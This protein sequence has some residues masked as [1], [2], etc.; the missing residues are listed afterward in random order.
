MKCF[1]A[2]VP[3]VAV[4]LCALA[5]VFALSLAACQNS[6][7]NDADERSEETGTG[8][9]SF[10]I[11]TET[12]DFVAKL[13]NVTR[14]GGRAATDELLLDVALTGGYTDSKTLAVTLGETTTVSFAE[15]PV[16]KEITVEASVY[17]YIASVKRVLCSGKS[18]P[19][20]VQAGG[21][22]IS[23]KL[24]IEPFCVSANGS[25]TGDGS[26]ANPFNSI[27]SA[28]DMIKTLGYARGNY[29]LKIVGTL[30]GTSEIP[31]DFTTSVAASL[32]IEGAENSSATLDGEGNAGSVLELDSPVP[33][34]MKSVKITH[35]RGKDID[36]KNS[37]GGIYVASGT[38]T[39][40][41]G[42]EV[43]D[44][45][46]GYYGGGIYIAGGTV[47]LDGAKVTGNKATAFG[48]YGGGIY[49]ASGTVTLAGSTEITNN[50]TALGY[51]GGIYI[52]NASD[53]ARL[54]GNV[55]VSGNNTQIGGGGIYLE[56]G[57]LEIDGGT[58]SGNTAIGSSGGGIYVAYRG[59]VT[60]K[61]GMIGGTTEAEG[62][63]AE[64][65]GGGVYIV[66]NSSRKGQ[67]TMTGGDIWNN[68]SD[69]GCGIYTKGIFSMSGGTIKNNTF[70]SG[71][72]DGKGKGVFL[73]SLAGNSF[74]L[75]GNAYIASTDDIYVHYKPSTP[76]FMPVT[77]DGTLSQHSSG[78]DSS[79]KVKITLERPGET[80][81][82]NWTA[83]SQIL[84]LREFRKVRLLQRVY[85]KFSEL[86]SKVYAF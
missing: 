66:C 85:D 29:T 37:A 26:E 80:D 3:A 55:K 69:S 76:N 27:S 12:V 9:V 17:Y 14:N 78:D 77:I 38:V 21:N 23:V 5:L 74:T 34:T 56:E 82:W 75:K 13:A 48:A 64:M 16:G 35:G 53:T 18:S 10:A 49:V 22:D 11:D 8:S 33:I 2:K 24:N 57:E 43:T 62:N 1:H 32:T 67:F 7:S 50:E 60:M 83:D 86:V 63:C 30:T 6:V 73:D 71:I 41:D 40:E 15:V 54:R 36:G 72:T 52:K 61:S 46:V 47:T 25:A 59:A 70:N 20:T 31:S 79:K 39:L 51:G 68:R 65:M 84:S 19:L 28:L 58:I 44:N 42:T 4:L 45:E 81:S